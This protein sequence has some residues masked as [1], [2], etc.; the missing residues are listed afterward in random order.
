MT[1]L[2]D[3]VDA[4]SVVKVSCSVTHTCSSHPPKFSWS[5]SNLTSEATHTSL[6]QGIW[7]MT[8]TITFLA[9]SGDGE[10]S[11]T[12]T[13]TYWR[14]RKQSSTALLIVTG[15]WKYCCLL[16]CHLMGLFIFF[17]HCLTSTGS[18]SFQLKRS[19]PVT[20]PVLILFPMVVFA[21]VIILK[22]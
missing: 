20:I 7:K 8:S 1:Q 14:G 10:R 4:G 15:Q 5:V 12:C 6:P 9:E 11:L 17:P 2:P 3:E 18:L 13:A 19:L 16:V 22:R 21:A